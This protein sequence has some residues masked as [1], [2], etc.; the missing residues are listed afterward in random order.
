MICI[1]PM[2]PRS[3]MA[4]LVTGLLIND[5]CHQALFQMVFRSVFFQE[6]IIGVRDRD[7]GSRFNT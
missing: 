7:L 3:L 6:L 2:A 1:R 4:F 5:R